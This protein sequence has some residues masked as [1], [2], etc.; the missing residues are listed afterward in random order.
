MV[1]MDALERQ[2]ADESLRIVGPAVVDDATIFTAVTAASRLHRWGFTMFSALKL[3]AAGVIVALFG[4]ILLAGLFTTQQGDEVVPVAVTAS[5]EPEVTGE[6]TEAL[7]TS[8]RTTS[9][10]GSTSPSKRSNPASSESST[11]ACVTW[12]RPTSAT[13]RPDTTVVSG[14]CAGRA[15]ARLAT[16]SGTNGRHG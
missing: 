14:S 11:T 1:D 3:V 2:L 15:S 6:P 12:R 16:T 5:P 7:T 4:G 13:S 8:V 10:P 9:C